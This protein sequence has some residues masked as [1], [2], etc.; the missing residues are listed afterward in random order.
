MSQNPQKINYNY[1][2][3]KNSGNFIKLYPNSKNYL[4]WIILVCCVYI[5]IVQFS[6]C[7]G[8]N[9]IGGRKYLSLN[10]TAAKTTVNSIWFNNERNRLNYTLNNNNDNSSIY[11]VNDVYNNDTKANNL[12]FEYVNHSGGMLP[13]AGT[14]L[15]RIE[16]K[17]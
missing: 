15:P 8:G 17:P 9:S 11:Y 6:L 4:L 2:N 12:V 3:Q 5:T 16:R 10:M 1:N 13:S 14:W 7:C